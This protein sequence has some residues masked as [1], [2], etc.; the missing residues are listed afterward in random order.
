MMQSETRLR[1][2]RVNLAWM[3]AASSESRLPNAMISLH[4]GAVLDTFNGWCLNKINYSRNSKVLHIFNLWTRILAGSSHRLS[5]KISKKVPWATVSPWST[6]SP[7]CHK[8]VLNCGSPKM[9]FGRT[10]CGLLHT[11]RFNIFLRSVLFSSPAW[12][13]QVE[14]IFSTNVALWVVIHPFSTWTICFT[15]VFQTINPLVHWCTTSNY[16]RKIIPFN[17]CTRRWHDQCRLVQVEAVDVLE[18]VV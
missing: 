1:S 14:S 15:L 8:N 3:F 12:S 11:Q 6:V 7:Q 17:R 4:S 18:I 13:C 16:K 10:S 5:L 9:I 2:G